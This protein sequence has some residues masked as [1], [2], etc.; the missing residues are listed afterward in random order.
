MQHLVASA[1]DL[2]EHLDVRF[3][4]AVLLVLI[5]SAFPAVRRMIHGLSL[6][7]QGA[8]DALF[9][10][11]APTDSALETVKNKVE[12]IASRSFATCMRWKERWLVR[13]RAAKI[14]LDDAEH[15]LSF[16]TRELAEAQAEDRM[17]P[18]FDRARRTQS[19]PLRT[20]LVFSAFIAVGDI[21]FTFAA[22]ELWDLPV[23]FLAPTCLLFGALGVVLGHYAGHAFAEGDR[24]RAWVVTAFATFYAFVLG[25]MRYAYMS[26]QNHDTVFG[27]LISSW[28]IIVVLVAGSAILSSY[29]RL[30][31]RLEKALV[32]ES[33][34]RSHRDRCFNAGQNSADVL[35]TRILGKWALTNA[36]V[37][38]YRRGFTLLWRGERLDFAAPPAPS[39]ADVEWP[40][41]GVADVPAQAA[42]AYT[43]STSS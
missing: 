12:L 4:L 17:A 20:Y 6:Q 35:R 21:V 8:S 2:V 36:L 43:V 19:I 10:I 24:V 33:R 28:G 26:R 13:A 42:R 34:A 30:A 23:V 39:V 9:K 11:K 29:L 3:V 38:A 32:K 25:T 18:R 31:T 40:P 41:K 5:A 22:F 15:A 27:N 14:A 16:A 37:H 7:L 1:S